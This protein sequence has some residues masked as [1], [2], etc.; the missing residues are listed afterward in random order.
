MPRAGADGAANYRLALRWAGVRPVARAAPSA[1]WAKARL[2]TPDRSAEADQLL[3]GVV[4]CG[5]LTCRR[6]PV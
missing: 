5:R 6:R 4:L 2:A 1:P 3:V